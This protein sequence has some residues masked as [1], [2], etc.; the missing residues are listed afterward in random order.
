MQDSNLRPIAYKAIA[1]PTELIRRVA[2]Y[3]HA[4]DGSPPPPW[5]ICCEELPVRGLRVI[6]AR[7]DEPEDV[8]QVVSVHRGDLDRDLLSD[9]FGL[10]IDLVQIL[11]EVVDE[12]HGFDKTA[13]SAALDHLYEQDP[14]GNLDLVGPRSS[15][16]SHRAI[17]IADLK[18][19]HYYL[20]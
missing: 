8:Q 4:K 19:Q 17:V 16:D 15:L 7:T 3:R 10:R 20:L 12:V 2:V 1:L 6:P 14:I 11:R 18:Q 5:R 13:L 9:G